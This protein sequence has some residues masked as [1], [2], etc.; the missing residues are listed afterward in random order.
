[1]QL[2]EVERSIRKRIYNFFE[3]IWEV[4]LKVESKEQEALIDKLPTYLK[5]ELLL[6]IGFSKSIYFLQY[7]PQ[8]A[9]LEKMISMRL[10]R[11]T[12]DSNTC[13]FESEKGHFLNRNIYF[14]KEGIA[15]PTQAWLSSTSREYLARRC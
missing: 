3:L 10:E 6:E 9:A 8:Q 12:I 1:M 15:P 4:E 11:A 5:E 14:I 13:I 7:M 2:K